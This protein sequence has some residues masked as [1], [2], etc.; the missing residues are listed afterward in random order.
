MPALM[1]VRIPYAVLETLAAA[2]VPMPTTLEQCTPAQSARAL[3]CAAHLIRLCDSGGVYLDL[4]RYCVRRA[5]H[6]FI[7]KANKEALSQ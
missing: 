5:C 2:S 7:A 4:E 6:R 1:K 3:A